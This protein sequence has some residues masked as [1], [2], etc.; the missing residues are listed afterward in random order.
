MSTGATRS[1]CCRWPSRPTSPLD[2]FHV[3]RYEAHPVLWYLLIYLG[4]SIL[5]S[6]L[7]LPIGRPSS[8]RWAR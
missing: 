3:I 6:P 2:L 4:D 7:M 1:A 8:C 5:Q